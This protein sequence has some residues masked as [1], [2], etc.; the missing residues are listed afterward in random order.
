VATESVEDTLNRHRRAMAEDACARLAASGRIIADFKA[1]SERLGVPLNAG[2]FSYIPTIGIVVTAVGLGRRLLGSVFTERDGL[3]AE[4]ELVRNH[5]S[6]TYLPG[7]FTGKNYMLMAHPYFRRGMHPDA[8]FAPRFVELLWGYQQAGVEKYVAIDEDRLRINVDGSAYFERDTWY[9]APF[10]RDIASI[11]V[12]G[13]KLRPPLGLEP[14]YVDFFFANAYCLDF[15]WSQ[16]GQIKTFQ[17]LEM[18][19][20]AVRIRVDGEDFFPARY[21]HAEFDLSAGC[22]RH[23]DGAVQLFLECEYLQRRDTDFNVNAKYLAQV[24]ARSK[25]LFKLNGTVSVDTWVEFCCHFLAGNPLAF[26]YFCGQY[27][28]HVVD[29]IEK[30]QT[31]RDNSP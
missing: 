12:G 27:P 26:E 30:L 5:K 11:P 25:K 18:K 29:A 23:F 31:R 21:L 13:G 28:R 22:F 2:S 20:D 3:F 6:N 19:S 16:V 10:S 8:N 9:G 17:A 1:F 24:K 14:P 7:Y 4:R 15:Q